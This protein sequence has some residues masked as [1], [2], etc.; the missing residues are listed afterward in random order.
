VRV[1]VGK[2]V[3]LIRAGVLTL[4]LFQWRRFAVEIVGRSYENQTG[5]FF[6]FRIECWFHLKVEIVN[7][8]P[9]N[10]SQINRL[11][12]VAPGG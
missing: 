12:F 3:R 1:F 5:T 10:S 8:N 11:G 9:P 4:R 7:T 2:C 6:E